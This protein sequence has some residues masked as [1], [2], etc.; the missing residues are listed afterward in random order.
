MRLSGLGVSPGIGIGKAL[1][2]KRGARDLHFR[3]PTNRVDRELRSRERIL[4]AQLAAAQARMLEPL[5]PFLCARWRSTLAFSR[6]Q[7]TLSAHRQTGA[8]VP[9]REMQFGQR[10]ERDLA[11]MSQASHAHNY[12]PCHHFIF[13][14]C[15]IALSSIITSSSC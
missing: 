15:D 14:I 12:S 6:T 1:V 11:V 8:E 3:I 4:L 10:G 13:G 2:L 7:T 9:R 5:K